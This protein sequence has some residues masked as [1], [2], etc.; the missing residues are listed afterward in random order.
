M[1]DI[2]VARLWWRTNRRIV[3]IFAAVT[4]VAS[5]VGV[6]YAATITCDAGM[7]PA[8]CAR[9]LNVNPPSTAATATLAILPILA[10]L[11]FGVDAVG[12]ETEG[13]TTAFAWSIATSRRRWLA[14]RIVPGALATAL[15]GL[16]CG[17]VSAVVVAKLNPGHDIAAS[18][19]GYGLWGPILIVRGLCAYGIGL[20][21]G[22][23]TGRVVASVAVGLILVT[24][25]TLAALVVGRSFESAQIVRNGDSRISDAL[26]VEFGALAPN[27]ELIQSTE[28]LGLAPADLDPAAKD[29]WVSV[30]C[31]F[32]SSYILGPQ[33]PS[34]E[35]RE[36]AALGA[37]AFVFGGMAFAVVANRR[38]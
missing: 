31:P 33:M 37:V 23:L 29:A 32:V 8:D 25:V 6:V 17:A 34:V 14:E 5:V 35:L 24:I 19:V 1:P 28:C 30:N 26:G 16:V 27:G 3:L 21:L 10:G 13:G 7:R 15:L 4:A 22:V 18:F 11:A 9:F 38:P 12:R 36:S 2:T 20:C